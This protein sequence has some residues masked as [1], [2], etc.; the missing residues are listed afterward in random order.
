MAEAEQQ[1]GAGE[2]QASL[3]RLDTRMRVAGSVGWLLVGTLVFTIV[4]AL[5]WSFFGSLPTHVQARGLL[6]LSGGGVR[7]VVATG[8]AQL[9]EVLVRDGEKVAAGQVIARLRNIE[10]EEKIF[11]LDRK[12]AT[13]RRDRARMQGFYE[14]FTEEEDRYLAELK[15]NTQDLLKG[16]EEQIAANARILEA[17]E[18]LL[19]EHYT[20]SIEVE[21]ARE[22]LF[23]SR[24]DRDQGRQKLLQVQIDQL[25]QLRQR[26]LTFEK[27]D[28]EIVEAQAERDDLEVERELGEAVVAP[29]SGQVVEVTAEKDAIV[30]EGTPLVLIEYGRPVL[31][32][33]LYVPAGLGKKIR[34]GQLA[35]VTPE[36]AKRSEYGSL[37]AHVTHVGLY[38][39]T[40]AEMLR[41]LNDGN[42]VDAWLAVGPVLR[43]AARLEPDAADPSGYR[44]SSGKGP[45]EV[46][47]VGTL[48]VGTVTVE[49]R[50]P[51]TLAIPAL[52]RLVG[53]YP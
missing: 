16:S 6:R 25:E 15:S 26:A 35:H 47:T 44:W 36:T 12:L 20:T 34:E 28:L 29:L 11:G 52:R 40:R 27:Y 19:S 10:L 24:A 39:A 37:V 42:L 45:N 2:Q 21:T 48:A 33:V 32:A 49:E 4:A 41:I 13:L 5:V 3:D 46:L 7:E 31:D 18:G 9:V 8:H 43:V 17:F 50:R 23:S 22:R 38:P 51:I 30:D 14:R 53:I 1:P